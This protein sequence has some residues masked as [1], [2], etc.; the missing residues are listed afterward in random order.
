MI[1]Q[2]EIYMQEPV[3]FVFI[4]GKESI[5]GSDEWLEF[6]KGKIGS[7]QAAIVMEKSPFG[8]PLSLYKEMISGESK[9]KVTRAMI[10]GRE[11][12]PKALEW[13]NRKLGSNFRP[14]VIESAQ[15]SLIIASL[16]G[17]GWFENR[18]IGCEIK[19]PGTEDHLLA[20]EGTIPE[21]YQ[22]QIQHQM[23]VSGCD[24]WI[25]V[26]WTG[27]EDTSVIIWLDRN[28]DMIKQLK[29]KELAFLEMVA[30]KTPPSSGDRDW[31]DKSDLMMLAYE[32]KRL[33]ESIAKMVLERDKIRDNLIFSAGDNEKVKIGDILKLQKVY[34][35]G[36][37]DYSSIPELR[38]VNLESYRKTSSCSWR[39]D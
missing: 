16:D 33:E 26:S 22:W 36:S 39:I 38:G 30:S 37:I 17:F 25:Y 21:K 23:M 34:R 32:Y 3:H 7:S 5:Q 4:W 19:A 8:T 20:I 1:E 15:N 31:V 9:T 18:W 29:E 35:K 14:E 12:E 28:E 2:E 6:K 24:K 10:R 11:E 13:L 27:N